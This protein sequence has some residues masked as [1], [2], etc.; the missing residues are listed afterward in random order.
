MRFSLSEN[1]KPLLVVLALALLFAPTLIWLAEAW[2]SDPYYSHGP[3]VLIGALGLAWLHRR[4]LSSTAR[5]PQVW[6]LGLVLVA[7]AVHLLVLPWRAYW[8][9]AL[10]LPVAL[11]GCLISL[12]GIQVARKFWFPLVFLLFM[13]PLPLAERVGPP[14]E[15]LA[16]TGSTVVVNLFGVNATNVGSQIFLPATS[17]Q[18]TV[19]VPCGGLRS[20][21]A[22]VTLI[23]AVAYLVQGSPYSRLLLLALAVPI[24]LAANIIRLVILF[25]IANQWGVEAGMK[26]FH[27]W[28]S[29]VLF[30]VALA[31]LLLAART[32]KCDEPAWELLGFH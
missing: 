9:S 30:L 6:G 19:G 29:P 32:L 13:V 17:S 16:A 14:L 22:L 27:D 8:V 2:L 4:K 28:A 18:F 21:I 31:L 3:L 15:A 24:A 26:Y 10:M 23:A 7:I 1:A 5:A 20:L 25:G 11:L 12:Y